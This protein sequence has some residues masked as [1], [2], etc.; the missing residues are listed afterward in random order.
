[1]SIN[2]VKY[3]FLLLLV[4][5]CGCSTPWVAPE[6]SATVPADK[7]KAKW[8]SARHKGVVEKVQKGNVELMFI[9]DSITHAWDRQADIFKENFGKW[10]PVNAGFSGDKTENVLWRLNNG[11]FKD[12]S[13]KLC[14]IMIG[15]N[16]TGH[17]MQKPQEI[18]DGIR[19]IIENI[20]A[21]SSSTKILLLAVFPRGAASNDPKRLNNSQVNVLISSYGEMYSFVEFMDINRKFLDEKGNLPKSIMPDLLHPNKEGYKIWAAA[22]K[23]KVTEMME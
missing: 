19:A 4:F 6:H 9:G 12:I 18:A 15:T 23:D 17:I 11:E 22:I 2:M 21:K 14:V 8:W 10:D 5:F 1:M 7:L 16:N 3:T 13:P 20:H